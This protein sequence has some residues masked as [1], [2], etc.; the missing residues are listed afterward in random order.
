MDEYAF[1]Y[2]STKRVIKQGPLPEEVRRIEKE[3]EACR[4]RKKEA[5][6]GSMEMKRREDW[7]KFKQDCLNHSLF[8]DEEKESQEATKEVYKPIVKR[9]ADKQI[10]KYGLNNGHK[11]NIMLLKRIISRLL[12]IVRKYVVYLRV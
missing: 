10:V 12:K 7:F 8:A 11:C 5:D 3:E 6:V 9:E 1:S 4:K 2:E